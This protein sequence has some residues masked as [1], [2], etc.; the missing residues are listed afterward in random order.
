MPRVAFAF[1]LLVLTAPASRAADPTPVSPEI[2]QQAQKLADQSLELLRRGEDAPSDEQRLQLY[3]QGLDLATR[4]VELDEANADAHFGIFGNK[5]RI[6]LLEG[7]GAN[8]VSVVTVN[9]DLDRA[10]ELN[11]DHADALTAKG[12][13]YRQLPWVLGGSL[14]VAEECLTKAIRLDP[15]AVSARIELA[16]TYRDMG[17][18]ERGLPLLET[19]AQIAERQGKK[20]QLREA[21][22]LMRELKSLPADATPAVPATP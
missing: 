3:K 7:V 12:G 15:E 6:L 13:L 16:A 20:R 10:L 14:T 9:H 17:Q 21:Q 2:K 5:G 22:D 11:P 4:A 8:P 18:P 1:L 19:A